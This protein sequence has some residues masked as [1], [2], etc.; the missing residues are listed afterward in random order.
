VTYPSD[1]R[2]PVPVP[3]MPIFTTYPPP[4]SPP[5]PRP[6]SATVLLLCAGAT[7]GLGFLF[8][9]LVG[10]G[11]EGMPTAGPAPQVT[12]TVVETVTPF[13]TSAPGAQ[14]T[15]SDQGGQGPSPDTGA[16]GPGATGPGGD[17]G[18]PSS[19]PGTGM[20]TVNTD[21]R[22]G[23]YTTTGPAPGQAGC[24]WARLRGSTGQPADIIDSGTPQGHAT[25]TVEPGD[26]LFVTN[27]CADWQGQ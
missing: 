1:P 5:E 7:A 2:Q 25:V 23:T 8:G 24:T 19:I 17:A 11:S 20:F 13:E 16:T 15:S 27:G 4:E 10:L 6:M 12:V 21:V 26:A 18:G 3:L 22:P 9:F 14:G